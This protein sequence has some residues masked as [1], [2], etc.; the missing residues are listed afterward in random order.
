MLAGKRCHVSL[1]G[2]AQVTI[3]TD[4]GGIAG[5]AGTNRAPRIDSGLVREEA[6]AASSSYG[7]GARM[8]SRRPL[9]I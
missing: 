7:K 5:A 9:Q 6:A 1:E 4:S 8:K 3:A 2:Q